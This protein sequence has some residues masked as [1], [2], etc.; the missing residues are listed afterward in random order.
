MA[1]IA[2]NVSGARGLI[3]LPEPPPVRGSEDTEV[4]LPLWDAFASCTALRE[5]YG[6]PPAVPPKPVWVLGAA[7]VGFGVAVAAGTGTRVFAAGA[8]SV[9]AAAGTV[10][11]AGTV[12]AVAVAAGV[13]VGG[14]GGGVIGVGTVLGGGGGVL[15]AAKP[16][17][18]GECIATP[19]ATNP[20][21]MGNAKPIV[22]RLFIQ[23]SLRLSLRYRVANCA[24]Q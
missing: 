11:V 8:V 5:L 24:A 21:A 4:P 16:E 7:K 17:F 13:L 23:D 18:A 19:S 1:A 6:Y 2:S 10:A 15:E 20:A 9:G 3:G 22:K 12:V 14:G